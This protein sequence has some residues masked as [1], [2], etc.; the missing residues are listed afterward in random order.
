MIFIAGLFAGGR[1][2][3]TFFPNVEGN[4]IYASASFVSGTPPDRV[5][6]FI[7]EVE[8]ALYAT[9]KQLGGSLLR[10]ANVANGMG[11]F[12]NAARGRA[13]EQFATVTAELVPSDAREIRNEEFLGAWKANFTEPAGLENIT[14]TSRRGGHPGR[15]L[16]I[17]LTG[18]DA[19]TLKAAALDLTGSLNAITGVSGIEDDMP[20]G[21]QQ[22]I[23]ELTAVARAQGLTTAEVGRQLRDTL[24]GH[25]VQIFVDGEEVGS[26]DLS[27]S[28]VSGELGLYWQG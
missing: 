16:E 12:S 17:R 3:F 27:V 7:E 25:L 6:V 2:G 22:L 21:Q 9:D 14:L 23:Y 13:G 8:Q 10:I 11:V 24:D 20:Y 4:I 26:N 19:D 1:L 18:A 28:L 5:T 15:D